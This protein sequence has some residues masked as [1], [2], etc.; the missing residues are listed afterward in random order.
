MRSTREQIFFRFA[1]A[2]KH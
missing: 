1:K 2:K